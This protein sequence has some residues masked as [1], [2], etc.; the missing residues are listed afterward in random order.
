MQLY[1]NGFIRGKLMFDDLLVTAS[2]HQNETVKLTENFTQYNQRC[3]CHHSE[4]DHG[5]LV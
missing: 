3:S 1:K 4:F 5:S 2:G